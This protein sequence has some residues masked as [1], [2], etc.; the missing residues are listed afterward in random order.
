MRSGRDMPV[1]IVI[2]HQ[3]GVRGTKCYIRR[4]A[5]PVQWQDRGYIGQKGGRGDRGMRPGPSE[6]AL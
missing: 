6:G 4:D 1:S 5:M 3:V 2:P